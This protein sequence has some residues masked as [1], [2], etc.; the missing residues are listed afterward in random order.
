MFSDFCRA[1]KKKPEQLNEKE[2]NLMFVRYSFQ[3]VSE[4]TLFMMAVALA[5]SP[6][7]GTALLITLVVPFGMNVF[8]THVAEVKILTGMPAP[9]PK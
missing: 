9:P 6:L 8:F 7:W 3:A 4:I 1:I 5:N 2:F